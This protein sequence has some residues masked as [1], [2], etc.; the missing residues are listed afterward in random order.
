MKTLLVH[1]IYNSEWTPDAKTE[2]GF[3]MS[4]H[5]YKVAQVTDSINPE[6]GTTLKPEQ[7]NVYCEAEDWKVTIK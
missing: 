3:P 1:Q 4:Q 6:I 5:V 2:S 7:M